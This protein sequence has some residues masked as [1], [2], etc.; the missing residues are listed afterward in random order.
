MQPKHCYF[1]VCLLSLKKKPTERCL[2]GLKQAV[3]HRL[4][5]QQCG[6]GAW[7]AVQLQALMVRAVA[8]ALEGWAQLL[9][10]GCS[11]ILEYAMDNPRIIHVSPRVDPLISDRKLS[12]AACP[13][14]RGAVFGRDPSNPSSPFPLVPA[15]WP[16]TEPMHSS[17]Q[18]CFSSPS[19]SRNLMEPKCPAAGLA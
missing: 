13:R 11:Q 14:N 3:S 8:W 15:L 18:S 1:L 17:T 5:L 7:V 19:S 10:T 12:V 6:A 2:K 9:G 16:L 4:P